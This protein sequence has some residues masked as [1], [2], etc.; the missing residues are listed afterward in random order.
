MTYSIQP[1]F[2]ISYCKTKLDRLLTQEEFNCL[3]S[4]ANDVIEGDFY[5][6]SQSSETY[7]LDH[8]PLLFIKQFIETQINRYFFDV[9]VPSNPDIKIYITQSWINYTYNLQEHHHHYHPNS[10]LSGVFYIETNNDSLTFI[11]PLRPNIVIESLVNT[12]Y[13]SGEIH[14]PVNANDLVIFPSYLEHKVTQLKR[15]GTRISLAFNTYVSGE[16][17][18]LHKLNKLAL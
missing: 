9:Y 3:N 14:I 16:I 5:K 6:N 15:Q 17:G 1:L 7:V 4:F 12:E 8:K 2:P 18:S 13:N 10:F 11:N